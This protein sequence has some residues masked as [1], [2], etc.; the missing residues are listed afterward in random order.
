[1]P[2][3]LRILGLQSPLLVSESKALGHAWSII[4]NIKALMQAGGCIP[5]FRIQEWYIQKSLQKSQQTNSLCPSQLHSLMSWMQRASRQAWLFFHPRG[6]IMSIWIWDLLFFFPLALPPLV[7][8]FLFFNRET[9]QL[10]SAFCATSDQNL[11]I[12]P[13]TKVF[14]SIKRLRTTEICLTTTLR[15][16][17]WFWPIY[18]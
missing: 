13:L 11:L 16:E 9:D 7:G 3:L 2:I 17:K 5:L 8:F 6:L 10:I 18:V 1:M 15:P 12:L 4:L 14:E